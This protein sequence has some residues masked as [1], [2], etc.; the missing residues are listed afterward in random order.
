MI[1]GQQG[2]LAPD[3]DIVP[4]PSRL[5]CS[6]LAAAFCPTSFAS[7]LIENSMPL[8]SALGVSSSTTRFLSFLQSHR[9]LSSG[10]VARQ[11]LHPTVRAHR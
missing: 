6:R 2:H 8:L 9:V 4:A 7:L 10:I 3:R 5:S 11:F 1:A